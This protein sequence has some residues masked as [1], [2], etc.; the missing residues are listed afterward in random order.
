[1][2]GYF[3]GVGFCVWLVV[4]NGVTGELG[5]RRYGALRPWWWLPM[6]LMVN[7]GGGTAFLL[8]YGRVP[9]RNGVLEGYLAAACTFFLG[10]TIARLWRRVRVH[11][12]R[13]DNRTQEA[14][15]N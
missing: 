8:L 11:T 12:L 15:E 6:L 10:V 14:G 4:C 7:G 3:L 9:G 2:L 5:R 1:V 13:K